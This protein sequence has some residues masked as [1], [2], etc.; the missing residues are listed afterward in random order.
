[1]KKGLPD[2]KAN[3]K[4]KLPK[5]RTVPKKIVKEPELL[6]DKEEWLCREFV[7]DFA[8]NQTRAYH[9]VWP[10]VTYESARTLAAK[11][12]AK[13]NIKRRI[14]ELREERNK[15]LE[16]SGDR[17]LSEIAKLSFYDP[18]CFFD[19]DG[20][21]KPIDEIDPDHAA[22]IGGIETL[23]KV[24]GDEKDGMAVITK[25][26]LADKG[27]NLERLGKYFKLFTDKTESTGKDGGPVEVN[28]RVIYDDKPQ[29]NGGG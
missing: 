12:F 21:L 18:R 2:K 10:N 17:V 23:H 19:S 9:R 3:K 24:V 25:I 11:V 8:E 13:V 29:Q 22:I 4:R 7:A 20:R 5:K 15:R 16:I 6:T 28:L 1:M 26:K 14:K 27:A